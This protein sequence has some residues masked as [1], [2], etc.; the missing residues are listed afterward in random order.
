M[1]VASIWAARDWETISKNQPSFGLPAGARLL[2]NVACS[3][4]VL[5][6][7]AGPLL[8]SQAREHLRQRL[9][10]A[11]QAHISHIKLGT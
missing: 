3:L 10:V 8:D 7:H 4:A 5:E 11:D 2:G 1:L 6:L 9:Q